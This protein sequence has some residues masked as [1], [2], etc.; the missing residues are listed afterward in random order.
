LRFQ[1]FQSFKNVFTDYGIANPE[2]ERLKARLI[3]SR[4]RAD[5]L[6]NIPKET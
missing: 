2:R 4:P 6:L 5:I 1:P 3:K